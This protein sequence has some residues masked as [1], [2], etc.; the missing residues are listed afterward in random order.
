M[1]NTQLDI[2]SIK[3]KSF[4][5]LEGNA[6]NPI[7]V[8]LVII[9]ISNV[10]AVILSSV[11]E[12]NV[13]FS[14]FFRVFELFSVMVFSIEYVVRIWSCTAEER[15]S[16]P[17][18]GRLEYALQPIVIVDLLAILPFYLPF[19]MKIDLRFLRILRIRPYPIN[20]RRKK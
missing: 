5:T 20:R 13:R 3:R 9:I 14:D 7:N 11:K 6:N 16:R 18:L 19:M 17:I 8:F 10:L 12:I 2:T 4:E 1:S 15:Y